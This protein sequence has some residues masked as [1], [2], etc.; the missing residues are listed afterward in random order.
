MKDREAWHAAVHGIAKS[1][2]QLSDSTTTTIH[3]CVCVLVAQS[4]PPLC[5]PMD[6]SLPG[7]SVHGILQARILGVGSH[8]LL[9]GIFLTQG[10]NPCLMGRFFTI[11]AIRE[12]QYIHKHIY[13]HIY[14]YL[15]LSTKMH[16]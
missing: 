7:S 11:G 2:M 4:Y 9:Q 13:S 1:Q 15:S 3:T 14:I 5:D 12:P 8:T 6:C 16:K 10:S